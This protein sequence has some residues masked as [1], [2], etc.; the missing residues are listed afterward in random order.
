MELSEQI[1][2]S[3]IDFSTYSNLNKKIIHRLEERFSKIEKEYL[4]SKEILEN[5]KSQK[6][7]IPLSVFQDKM[8]SALELV[9]VFLKEISGLSNTDISKLL[10]RDPKTIWATYYTARKKSK[11]QI[12]L[13]FKAKDK[14]TTNLVFPVYIFAKRDLSVLET[15][16]EYLQ[17]NYYLSYKAIADH[18]NRNEKTIATIIRRINE[19]RKRSKNAKTKKR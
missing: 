6:I 7:M 14:N 15:L 10:N 12:S 11:K 8:L 5:I 18:L 13:S 17:K 1:P 16:V 3:D 19:K 4:L 2:D 9:V